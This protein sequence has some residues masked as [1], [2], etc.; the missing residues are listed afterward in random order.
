M[1]KF[2]VLSSPLDV[3][4]TVIAISSSEAKKRRQAELE[5]ARKTYIYGFK[6]ISVEDV[7]GSHTFTYDDDGVYGYL[8]F[9][10]SPITTHVIKLYDVQDSLDKLNADYY[11]GKLY[12]LYK[13]IEIL[14]IVKK[15]NRKPY[16]SNESKLKGKTQ[17]IDDF[18]SV[19]DIQ[20]GKFVIDTDTSIC[21]N[22]SINNKILKNKDKY[23]F[24]P[25]NEVIVDIS[26]KTLDKNGI[27]FCGYKILNHGNY[28][29]IPANKY[30]GSFSNK[31]E[32]V[33]YLNTT[34]GT[35]KEL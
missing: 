5:E 23:I 19:L 4:K 13:R 7:Y 11:N 31:E 33:F 6:P 10:D 22:L 9:C 14:P 17:Y 8:T 35:L 28:I 21:M 16:V 25:T 12:D 20:N 29:I 1:N 34:T 24:I 27:D 26:Y 30:N 2:K 15:D 18:I 32:L 3:F